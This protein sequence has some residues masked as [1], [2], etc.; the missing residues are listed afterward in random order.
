[1]KV[2]KELEKRIEEWAERLRS[3]HK[4]LASKFSPIYSGWFRFQVEFRS[5][6]IKC[7]SSKPIHFTVSLSLSPFDPLAR[8]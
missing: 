2:L 5:R 6:T 4:I 8:P 1:M 3:K 7:F